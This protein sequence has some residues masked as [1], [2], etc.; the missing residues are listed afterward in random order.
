M[1]PLHNELSFSYD[2][3]DCETPCPLP[4]IGYAK[5]QHRV[6]PPALLVALSYTLNSR[7]D[8]VPWS[9]VAGADRHRDARRGPA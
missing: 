3:L 6:A 1:Q 5:A 2:A 8:A 7:P 9:G 4:L